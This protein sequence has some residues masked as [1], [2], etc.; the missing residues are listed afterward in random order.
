MGQHEKSDDEKHD[1][2][3]APD[4][5]IRP[6]GSDPRSSGVMMDSVMA[7]LRSPRFWLLPIA[8][9]VGVMSLLAVSYLGAIVNPQRNLHDFHIALVNEDTGAVTGS[10]QQPTRQVF[11]KQVVDGMLEGVKGTGIVLDPVDRSTAYDR[12]NS[13]QAFAMVIIPPQFSQHLIDV[14]GSSVALT[15]PAAPTIEVYSDR[16]SGAFASAVTNQF[17]DRLR[18]QVNE[19]VGGQLTDQVRTRLEQNKVAFTGAIQVALAAPVVFEVQEASPLPDGA[20]GGLSAFY[21]TLLLILAGFTGAMVVH[22]MVDSASGFTPYEAGPIYRQRFRHPISRFGTVVTKWWIMFLV[23]IIQSSLYLLIAWAVGMYMPNAFEL[24]MFSVL[25]ITAVGITAVAVVGV[26]GPPGLIVNL[27]FFVILGLPS[28]G[29]ALPL[30]ASPRIFG[31]LAHVLPMHQVYLGVRS[32][33]YFDG[34]FTAG[35][36]SAILMCVIGLVLGLVLGL[37]TKVY[38]ARGLRREHVTASAPNAA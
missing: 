2:V 11:G 18:T 28:S 32:I 12:L 38:D 23:A 25:A 14:A 19:K 15:K 30:E 3:A 24:W 27:I 35:L 16:R 21:F 1:G 22:S 34:S 8:A 10:A 17:A 31:V 33:T 29:G 7:L 20:A 6:D 36:G 4:P 9:V 5:A 13:A 37:V 26:F